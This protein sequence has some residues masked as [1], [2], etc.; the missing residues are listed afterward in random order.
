MIS[1]A[2]RCKLNFENTVARVFALNL[3]KIRVLRYRFVAMSV[4][5]VYHINYIN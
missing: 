2:T 1:I 3:N 5:G 4:V